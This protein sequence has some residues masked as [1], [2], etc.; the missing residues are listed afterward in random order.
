MKKALKLLD[1][2]EQV[3]VFNSP[4][5]PT[6]TVLEIERISRRLSQGDLPEVW[7]CRINGMEGKFID[8]VFSFAN[9]PMLA[10]N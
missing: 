1:P 10:D 5:S 7:Q 9:H 4:T 2:H 3:Q 8:K 6:R